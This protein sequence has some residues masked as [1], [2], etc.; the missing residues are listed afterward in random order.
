MGVGELSIKAISNAVINISINE[1]GINM[2]NPFSGTF[3]PDDN[4][5]K[6]RLPIPIE[7]IR[8]IQAECKN[9]NDDNRWL[10][11]LISD[12]GMRLSEACGLLV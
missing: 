6:T 11:A 7:N 10:I 4:K 2:I 12:T 9:L 5:K 8:N 1:I 3:I